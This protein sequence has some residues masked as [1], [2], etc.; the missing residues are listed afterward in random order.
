M[1]FCI[2]YFSGT[3]NT[4]WIVEKTT[5]MLQ[6]SNHDI[7]NYPIENL[8]K[9]PSSIIQDAIKNYDYIGLANPMYGAN[10]PR[11]MR[12]FFDEFLVHAKKCAQPKARLFFI[13]TFAYINGFGIFAAKKIFTEYKQPIVGYIN[14]RLS[15]N[16]P[17]KK[18]KN[19]LLG[20]NML[21]SKKESAIKK[22][23]S[24]INRFENNKKTIQ[25][26]GPHLIVGKIIRTILKDEIKN[27]F[28][29]M[30]ID[31]KTCNKCMK[32]IKNCPTNSIVFSNGKF[33][34]LETCEACMRCYNLCPTHSI[35]NWDQP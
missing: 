34:F 32:C 35:S 8:E 21:L 11:I 27:N 23:S 13:N 4:K 7:I 9:D 20:E 26:V 19:Y 17:S 12:I 28:T 29:R 30:H 3:G 15:I 5:T 25:G 6:D 14:F 31:D 10:V 33:T 2:F 22:I 24:M 18:R 1:K 16:T